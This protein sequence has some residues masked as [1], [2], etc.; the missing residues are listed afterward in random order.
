M[1]VRSS[2]ATPLRN[3]D[4]RALIVNS[5][6]AA[7]SASSAN[8]VTLTLTP[9]VAPARSAKRLESYQRYLAKKEAYAASRPPSHRDRARERRSTA[10]G[11]DGA[12]ALKSS[13]S[14]E[15]S[16]YLGGDLAHTHLVRG[17]D[18]ALLAAGKARA[19]QAELLAPRVT[20]QQANKPRLLT[21][22]TTSDSIGSRIISI[23][24]MQSA[25]N[26]NDLFLPNRMAFALPIRIDILQPFILPIRTVMAARKTTEFHSERSGTINGQISESAL[27]T[28]TRA[29]GGTVK[30]RLSTVAAA[31]IHDATTALTSST[32]THL[33]EPIQ[34]THRHQSNDD[35]DDILFSDAILDK[36]NPLSDDYADAVEAAASS[37]SATSISSDRFSAML[38]RAEELAARDI[39]A[40]EKRLRL[41]RL[42]TG[43]SQSPY[44]NS[45]LF[46]E[47]AETFGGAL[48]D[49][50]E[51]FTN[52]KKRSRDADEQ[53]LSRQMKRK[54]ESQYRAVQALMTKSDTKPLSLDRLESRTAE[55]VKSNQK[56]MR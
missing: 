49:D 36:N 7:T 33:M 3:A 55:Y 8:N 41:Q 20:A 32:Q 51:D 2:S 45:D 1:S 6:S 39:A 30:P 18:Y 13:V 43:A 22:A 48:V 35:D 42:L 29:C 11:T 9:P 31:Q 16:A 4:F 27:E 56:R 54:E 10:D 26:T 37:S 19:R 17:L 25:S 23:L 15:N 53:D 52:K 14:A 28:L 40:E 44:D 12:D 24:A 38:S 50:D 47:S 21:A 46:I 5:Q 34:P